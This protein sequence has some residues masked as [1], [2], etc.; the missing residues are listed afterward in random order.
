MARFMAIHTLP[1]NAVS[2]E[3]AQ[4]ISDASQ[5]DQKV[6]GVRSFIN[7]SEGKVVCIMDATNQRDL[8]EWYQKMGLP[9]DMVCPV[10]LEGDRGS[11]REMTPATAA[12]AV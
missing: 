7:L 5:R 8:E 10:E 3:Q 1:A 6:H 4:Q 11:L 9:Y 2:R 12:T